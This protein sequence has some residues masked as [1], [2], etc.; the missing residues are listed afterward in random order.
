M[1]RGLTDSLLRNA[2]PPASGRTEFSDLRCVGL[3]FRITSER[4]QELV[5]TAFRDRT[6]GRL[7]RA[8]IGQFPTIGLSAARSAADAM[9]ARGCEAAATRLSKKDRTGLGGSGDDASARLPSGIWM[10]T[11]G[12]KSAVM[13]PMERNLRLHVLPRWKNRAYAAI[14]RADVIELVE[15][16]GSLTASRR[17]PTG[18]IV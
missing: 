8:T 9:R 1:Q 2:R 17:W 12:G 18:F 11:R 15:G 16:S 14:R 7:C 5:I 6:T 13:P 10:N 4:Y 3:T